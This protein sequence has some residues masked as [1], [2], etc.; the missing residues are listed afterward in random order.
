MKRTKT[1]KNAEHLEK[2][3]QWLSEMIKYRIN[4][5]FNNKE[6]GKTYNKVPEPPSF[7]GEPSVYS[8]FVELYKLTRYERLLL[9]LSLAPIIDPSVLDTFF[10]TDKEKGKVFTSFG[11]VTSAVHNGFLPSG[12]TFVFIAAG[13]DLSLRFKLFDLFS[14]DHAFSKDGVLSIESTPTGNDPFLSGALVPSREF[15]DLFTS[16][17][18]R[19]PV[20]GKDFPAKEITTK[21]EWEDLVLSVRT[22]REIGELK[23]WIEHGKT[24]MEDW[25]LGRKLKPGY[26]SL[27]Y[28]PP[29]TGKTLTATLVAKLVNKPMFRIDLSMIVSKYIGETEKNLSTVFDQAENKD[30][31]LFFDEADAL[32]GKRTKVNDAHDRYANQEVSYLLQRIEEFSGLVILASNL[33]SNMDEAFTRRFQSIIHFPPPTSEERYLLWKKSFSE[34]STLENTI[35]LH[36]IEERYEISGGGIMNVVRYC[37][38]LA[39]SRGSSEILKKEIEEGIRREYR[40][41]G[42]LV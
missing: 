42:K 22:Q 5:Y 41:D 36:E 37:S 33:K 35:D 30:W 38:L 29:G 24:V 11:G 13:S 12:E 28:G 9:I 6:E 4:D 1:R 40:K 31:I 23:T 34:K 26:L 7:E 25:G 39:V 21:Y 16:G 20:F 3:I 19:K 27:F 15:I 14:G 2:E 32:F 18:V 17:E 8:R 10:I